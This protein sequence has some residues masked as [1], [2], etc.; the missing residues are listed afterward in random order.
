[1]TTDSGSPTQSTTTLTRVETIHAARVLPSVAPHVLEAKKHGRIRG[2]G[3]ELAEDQVLASCNADGPLAIELIIEARS[4]HDSDREDR[5]VQRSTG[6]VVH[7]AL[8]V[9]V[10]DPTED[11][12]DVAGADRHLIDDG[13]TVARAL[14]RI[15][16]LVGADDDAAR[17]RGEVPCIG[18][19]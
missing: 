1:S 18:Q 5:T 13:R 2:V 12:D 17:L 6:E 8:G 15:Q 11:V 4:H 9:D 16:T 3:L 10:R 7:G 19:P 14:R